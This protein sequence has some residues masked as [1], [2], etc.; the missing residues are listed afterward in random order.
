MFVKVIIGSTRQGR[1]S[2]K[3]AKW[4]E[5]Q[6]QEK[7]L[8]NFKFQMLDLRDFDLPFMYEETIPFYGRYN[9]PKTSEW[10]KQIAEADAFI[11]ITPEYN[12]GYPGILKNALDIIYP[13]WS[14][15]PVGFISYGNA[16]GARVIEQLRQ[17]ALE[18]DMIP[19]SRSI[20]FQCDTYKAL[21]STD[22]NDDNFLRLFDGS[23]HQFDSF[24]QELLTKIPQ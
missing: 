8:E 4:V 19:L 18:L 10:S 6:L 24:L 22:I 7:S 2:E 20:N 21:K 14:G 15:K 17:V 3:P 12:H 13:E 23:Q 16:G 1:F 9:D 5:C 11:I